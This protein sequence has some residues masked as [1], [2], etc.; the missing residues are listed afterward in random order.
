MTKYAQFARNSIIIQDALES[1]VP[2]SRM[3]KLIGGMN[4]SSV[5]FL[6]TLGI[7]NDG[8]RSVKKISLETK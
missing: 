5:L 6:M 1:R 7:I 3:P 2:R 4:S 8:I